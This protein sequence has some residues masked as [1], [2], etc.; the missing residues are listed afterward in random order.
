LERRSNALIKFAAPLK[1]LVQRFMYLGLVLGAFSFMLLGKF[2]VAMV[3]DVRTEVT[4]ALAPVLLAFSRPSASISSYVQNIQNLIHTRSENNR[5]TQENIRLLQWQTV[6]RKLL[7]DNI[8]LRQQLHVVKDSSEKYITARVIAGS[9][10]LLSNMLILNAGKKNGVVRGQTVIGTRGVIGRISQVSNSSS[11]VILLTDINSRVPVLVEG[12]RTR[13]VLTGQNKNV[14]TLIYL[15]QAAKIVPNDRIVTSGHGGAFPS[16]L[17][18]GVVA[19]VSDDGVDVRLFSDFS[20]LEYVRIVDFG[21]N[22][23]MKTSQGKYLLKRKSK[24]MSVER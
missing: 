15:P 21:L 24:P 13:A 3:E 4:E 22:N 9:G 18:I 20:R 2:D 23:L 19:S 17:P 5:L 10:G 12:N 6:A 14:A 11:R 8:A 1:S 7:S 16:G